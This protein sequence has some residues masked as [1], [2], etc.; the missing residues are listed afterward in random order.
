MTRPVDLQAFPE[1]LQDL[2]PEC[3]RLCLDVERFVTQDLGADLTGKRLVA[4]LSGGSDSTALLLVFHYLAE[5]NNFT[6]IAAHFNHL[7]RPEAEYESWFVQRMAESLGL[8]YRSEARDVRAHAL[9]FKLGLEE[10]GRALRYGFLERLR[11]EMQAD[12]ILLGHHLDDLTEDILLRLVRGA[13]WPALGGMPGSDSIRGIL[14]PFLLTPKSRLIEFL[15][16]LDTTWAEDASNQ[17]THFARNR[18]RY[19]VVPMLTRENPNLGQSMARLWRQAELDRGFFE[20]EIQGLLD[21]A[22]SPV[23]PFK[24]NRRMLLLDEPLRKAHPAMRLRVFK[25]V[26][27]RQGP[28]QVLADTLLQL[29]TAFAQ[30]RIGAALQFPGR[31]IARVT[32]EG[33]W[34]EKSK[35]EDWPE[36]MEEQTQPEGQDTDKDET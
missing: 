11:G 2:H 19:D 4:A 29:E 6:L 32:N 33:I 5:R 3:A 18:M 31:K 27:E 15:V 24:R 36:V 20:S 16:D 14:R 21:T 17:D 23:T 35:D 34:F 8:T 25:R 13:G 1:K 12:Y 28:G 22:L 9:E 30:P 26:L 7:L 10:A